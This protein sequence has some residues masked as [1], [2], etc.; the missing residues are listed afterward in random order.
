MTLDKIPSGWPNISLAVGGIGVTLVFDDPAL[1]EYSQERYRDFR[2]E[3]EIF[4][5]W[6]DDPAIAPGSWH[7]S[8]PAYGL[9]GPGSLFQR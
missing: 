7:T 1:A 9:P 5:R 3:A 4:I 2:S 8:K 6:E